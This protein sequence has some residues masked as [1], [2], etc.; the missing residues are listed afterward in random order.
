MNE[1]TSNVLPAVSDRDLR[2][3]LAAVLG[4][5]TEEIEVIE[6]WP[7]VH[8]SS[9]PSEIVTMRKGGGKLCRLFCKYG[10]SGAA[11]IILEFSQPRRPSS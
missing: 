6:R 2:A 5:S 3:G 1:A 10:V 8:A 4:V 9:F 7:N 11:S